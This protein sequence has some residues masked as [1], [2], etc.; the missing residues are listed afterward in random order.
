M[1]NT[2]V[3]SLILQVA[4]YMNFLNIFYNCLLRY[5]K[6][7]H[8]IEYYRYDV[9]RPL[10]LF[11]MFFTFCGMLSVSCVVLGYVG[12]I[13]LPVTDGGVGFVG[14]SSCGSGSTYVLLLFFCLLVWSLHAHDGDSCLLK[15]LPFIR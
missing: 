5:I 6:I 7:T 1:T 3:I 15:F 13:I 2:I 12:S 9:Y 14:D 10:F 4:T 8:Y 11:V